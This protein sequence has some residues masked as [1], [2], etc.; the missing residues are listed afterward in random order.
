MSR[1]FVNDPPVAV[2]EFDPSAVISDVRPNV[3][4]IRARMDVA[5]DAKVKSE[6]FRL[7]KDSA[8]VEAHLGAN[9]MALLVH[10][11]VR[12]EGPDLDGVPCTPETIRTLD[13]TEPHLA[14]VL[15][16]IAERNK[17]PAGPSPKS[18]TASTSA[19]A[20]GRDSRPSQEPGISMQLATGMSR[21]PLQSAIT[22][23]LSRSDD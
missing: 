13:P 21:S 1:Y 3:I 22:G 10:N 17:R 6:L 5:T 7:G 19:S 9:Q 16:A 11:I 14:L 12:W 2:P 15:E 8:S 18:A 23:R 4:Y 20:G